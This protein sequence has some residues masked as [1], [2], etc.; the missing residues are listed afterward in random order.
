[1]TV[2][3]RAMRHF[4][5]AM[6]EA[7]AAPPLQPKRPAPSAAPLR[8]E[9]LDAGPPPLRTRRITVRLWIPSTALFC[10]L[11]PFALLLAPL[12]YLSPR[13]YRVP[14]FAA[15]F[16]IGR[17]LISLGGTVVHVDTPEALISLRLF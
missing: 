10:L 15:A 16:A 9:V 12:G 4:G 1:M 17:L 13:P 2:Y 5:A 11:A 6:L 14:P 3:P 8:G 7:E